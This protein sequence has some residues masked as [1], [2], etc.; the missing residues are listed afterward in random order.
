MVY[1]MKLAEDGPATKKDL[2]ELGDKLVW[3][4]EFTRDSKL[5]KM[6]SLLDQ[7]NAVMNCPILKK[8]FVWVNSSDSLMF[9]RIIDP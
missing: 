4:P 9:T 7:E 1:L 2:H 5:K 6:Q 3:P 8:Y